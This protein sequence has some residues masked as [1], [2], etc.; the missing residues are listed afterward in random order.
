MLHSVATNVPAYVIA[1]KE[2]NAVHSRFYNGKLMVH[3]KGQWM[4]N[5]DYERIRIRPESLLK[6][7]KA[8]GETIGNTLTMTTRCAA[9]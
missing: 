1:I 9:Y 3:Y 6:V 7:T 2:H 8:L 5:E 4:P